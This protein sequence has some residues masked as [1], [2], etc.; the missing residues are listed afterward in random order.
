LF[1]KLS[2]CRLRRTSPDL[3]PKIL[4]LAAAIGLVAATLFAQ[5]NDRV[6]RGLRA[7][8]ARGERI[9]VIVQLSTEL[10]AP[11]RS[12]N[13][14]RAS[15]ISRVQERV[16][17]RAPGLGRIKRLRLLPFVAI[18]ADAQTLAQLESD[19]DVV[20]VQADELRH[21]SLTTSVPL[22][23]APTAWSL[24]ASGKGWSIAVLDT[25]VDKSH[26]FL[27]GRVVSEACYSSDFSGFA[28]STCPGGDGAAI[29]SG[30]PCSASVSGCDHG[31]HVAG[32]A[33]GHNGSLSG[34]A[35]DATL[36][37]IKVFSIIHSADFCYPGPSPCLGAYDSDILAGLDRVYAL[38]TQFDI[39]AV[40]MSLA[41]G[42]YSGTCDASFPAYKSAIDS[43]RN[44]GIATVISSGN[45]GASTR[46]SAPA[47]VSSAIS[48]GA[49]TKSD[50]IA[51]FSNRSS[52]LKLLAP[53]SSI[54]SSVPGG[55]YATFSGTS[56]A[57]PHVAGAWAVMR[58]RQPTASVT[59]ILNA[60]KT[61]G[62]GI[63]DPA[64]G[65]TRRRIKLDAA[66]K[67]VPAGAPLITS[68]TA[69]PAPPQPANAPIT[70]T[71]RAGGGTASLEYKFWLYNEQ[72]ASWT[73]LQDYSTSRSVTWTPRAIGAY[74]LQVWVRTVVSN[75]NYQTWKASGSFSIVDA[76][77]SATSF[78]ADRSSPLFPAVATT[79][80]VGARGGS[81]PLE[82]KFWR[83]DL[84]TQAWTVV[85]D[86]GPANTFTWTPGPNERGRYQ[87]QVWVRAAGSAEAYEA[88]KTSSAFALLGTTYFILNSEPGDYIGQGQ[89]I[90]HGTFDGTAQLQH[91]SAGEN[92]NTYYFGEG[93]SYWWH[94]D[95][96][97]KSGSTL[98][99]G[100]YE[101]AIRYPFNTTQPGLSV[102][103]DGR[104][105]NE[106]TGRFVV[107]D[108][109]RNA[110]NEIT[111]FAA[112]FEQ[113]CENSPPGLRGSVRYNS[114]V[115]PS[116]GPVAIKS[117]T[118]NVPLPPT[119]GKT[120]T[121][122]AVA[123]G[124][125]PPLRYRFWMHSSSTGAW[126]L[127]QDGPSK[128]FT[129]TPAQAATYTLQVWVKSTNS[130]AAYE[131]SA[132]T[133]IFTVSAVPVQVT[134]FAANVPSPIRSNTPVTWSATTS[135][136][137]GSLEY[138]FW[139]YNN[140]THTWT[141][142]QGYGPQNTYTWQPT[143]SEIGS[144]GLQVWVRSVGSSASWEAWRS[145]GTFDVVP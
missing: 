4:A 132:G 59:E 36:I 28:E 100:V 127:L 16:L 6:P 83:H 21:Q 33:A 131:A 42:E 126:S 44:V 110:S 140:T 31:T 70:W 120:V 122:T 96:G 109:A 118:A 76:P 9:P 38:R 64:T 139:R 25:G 58:S 144:Y 102:D 69:N 46:I 112:D 1:A 93:L 5:P 8:A 75:A 92:I 27:A 26:P 85:Q 15:A 103:G 116:D 88:A 143:P 142:V 56:M 61:T 94:L 121:W 65:V 35:Q 45:D 89:R 34:V 97:A 86:Y 135:G 71:A 106:V 43:L 90:I 11:L 78:T 14:S 20:S 125:G 87:F 22:I 37:A 30:L 60:L 57:A 74:S 84:E 53:G 145:S 48:V 49:T 23:G 80:T 99:P 67:S 18:E 50:K 136:G 7:R 137:N 13:Q 82:Y 117:F 55:G 54:Y 39:A 91:N 119:L 32:I 66:V 107:M 104:G 130:M 98:A 129:W 29:N 138:Q 95:F 123:T 108:L 79:W 105:C 114:Q 128:T 133:P 141:V 52:A 73:V 12:S 101:Q 115:P 2:C 63:V 134:A 3:R 19:P 62:L 77:V 124:G 24:G 51:S 40:N 10:D 47:C 68:L 81:G 17:L 41:E 113:H 72:T 111:R